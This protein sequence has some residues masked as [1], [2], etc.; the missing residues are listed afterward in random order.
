MRHVMKFL[1]LL[2]VGILQ[3]GCGEDRDA[4]YFE[5]AGGGFIFNYRN[6]ENYYGFVAR[7][8]RRL[9]EDAILEAHFEM[10]GGRPNLVL[11][12]P[13]RPGRLQYMFRT[14]NLLGIVKGH[15]YKVVLKLVDGKTGT[16]LG[17]VEKTFA[18]E[19][20]QA[21]LPRKPLVIGPG[22]QQPQ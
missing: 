8:K 3:S 4:P 11:S 5:F 1:M 21:L 12:E 17:R 7:P 16:E 20:D 2:A 9:P 18:T 22:Y 6:A 13:V 10:P 14:G 15:P 19:V